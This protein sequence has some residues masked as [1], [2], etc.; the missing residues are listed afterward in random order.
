MVPNSI[1]GLSRRHRNRS[2]H[3][4]ANRVADDQ[5]WT[6]A[7][8]DLETF[9]GDT[10]ALGNALQAACA[11]TQGVMVF[12]LSHNIEPLWPFFKQAFRNAAKAPHAVPAA[13]REARALRARQKAMGIRKPPLVIAPG[14]PGAGF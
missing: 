6:Y 1:D 9:H 10:T 11:S 8:I 14:T 3:R 2:R 13:L 4:R 7:G 12:D 5:C